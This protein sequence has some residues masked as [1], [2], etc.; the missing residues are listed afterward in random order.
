MQ[1][2]QA[3]AG[4]SGG[5]SYTS[6]T[7]LQNVRVLAIDQSSDPAKGAQAMVGAVATL[8][9]PAAD[10]EVLVRAKAQG[11]VVLALR[12]YADAGGDSVQ[13][14]QAAGEVH[15]WRGGVLSEALVTP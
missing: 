9:V 1:A 11:E 4:A 5:R 15:V 7:L 12:S 2:K 6:Q 13:A 14:R 3:E 8:E 10:S